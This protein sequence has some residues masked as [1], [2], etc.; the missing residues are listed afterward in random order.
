MKHM[1]IL[2]ILIFFCSLKTS[3]QH[4]Q[5][6]KEKTH[7][8][9]WRIS[10]FIGHTFVALDKGGTHTPIASWALDIEYWHNDKIGIGLHND[11][12]IESFIVEE[13]AGEFI[14]RDFP[15]VVSL[16][17]LFKPWKGLVL[18]AGPGME[19]DSNENFRLIRLG[20]EYEFIINEHIDIAPTFFH[21]N[22]F[23]AFDTW[24]IALGVGWRF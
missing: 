22:R 3:A 2:T 4:S 7:H 1:P 12:E 21:D 8:P 15:I 9:H 6:N 10:P 24:T 18:Y 17:V 19:F 16:D 11:L 20:V 14:E 5:P 13:Q 23:N